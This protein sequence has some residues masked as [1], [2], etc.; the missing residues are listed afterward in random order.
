MCRIITIEI[1]TKS[2]FVRQAFVK[3][4]FAKPDWTTKQV[5]FNFSWASS[6]LLYSDRNMSA[7]LT[8]ITRLI[9]RPCENSDM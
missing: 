9:S 1:I 2:A 4:A 6:V 3:Q 8:G 7:S 5:A